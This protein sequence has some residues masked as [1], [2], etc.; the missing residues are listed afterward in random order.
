LAFLWFLVIILQYQ[1][2]IQAYENVPFTDTFL[3]VSATLFTKVILP[4]SVGDLG[5]REGAS[6]FYY[7]LMNVPR[8]AAFNAAFLIFIINFLLP[9]LAGSIFVFRLS[10]ENTRLNRKKNPTERN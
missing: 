2:V 1:T 6:V 7:S 3:A 9:A 4:V 8:P 10:W 5:I